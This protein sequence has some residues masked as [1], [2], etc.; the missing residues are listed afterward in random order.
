MGDGEILSGLLPLD[1]EG[2]QKYAGQIKSIR[3]LDRG[4]GYDVLP[5][6]DLTSSGDGTAT[7]RVEITKSF[8]ELPGRWTTSDGILSTEERR[9]QGRDYYVNSA[10]VLN[11]RLEF[12]KFKK[13]LLDLIHPAGMNAFAECEIVQD[14]ISDIDIDV[15]SETV[16]TVSGLVETNGTIYVVGTSTK[17]AVANT[18]GILSV[19]STISINNETRIVNAIISNTSLTVSNAFSYSANSQTLVS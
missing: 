8:D 9:L 17:F 4:L 15:F 2:N 7:A 19:G 18:Y 6:A 3:I 5:F 14:V 12:L 10:Y 1:E 11:S 16:K 13:A